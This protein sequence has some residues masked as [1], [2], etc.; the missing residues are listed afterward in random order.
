[1]YIN[2]KNSSPWVDLVQARYFELKKE[3]IM[4]EERNIIIIIIITMKET[5]FV[6]LE[7]WTM[8]EFQNQTV[9]NLNFRV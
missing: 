1:M 3:L 2:N 8:N 7:Y 9:P 6:F 5:L 4:S